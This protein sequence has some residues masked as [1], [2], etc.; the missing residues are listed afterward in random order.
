MK[1][2]AMRKLTLGKDTLTKLGADSLAK[3]A[4]GL[5]GKVSCITYRASAC[6]GSCQTC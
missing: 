5:S 6:E 1:K 4:G 2:T 3:V